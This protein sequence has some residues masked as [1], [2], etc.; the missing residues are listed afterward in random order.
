M[1]EPVVITIGWQAIA[2]LA[3]ILVAIGSGFLLGQRLNGSATSDPS[4]VSSPPLATPTIA[5]QIAPA[6]VP[7]ANAFPQD[8]VIELPPSN[9]PLTGQPAPDF[10]MRVLGTGEDVKLSDC[11]GKPVL[12]DFWA[13]WC[14]PCRLEMPWLEAVYRAHLEEDFVLLAVDAGE[15][16][17]PSMVEQAV[18]QFVTQLGLTFPVLLGDNTYDVQRTY[19]VY[20]LPAAYLINREGVVVDVHTGMFPNQATIESK[21]QAI[22][23]SSAETA[24]RQ[25]CRFS[26][27]T[28][29]A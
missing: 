21:L 29:S 14:P 10:Q 2:M 22:L 18:Q 4:S 7:P 6:A 13:T 9:H 8:Q 12:V 16:V 17:P 25:T 28:S 19:S 24:S 1:A 26:P 15:R 23:P 3:I 11:K 20:G 27:P 5:L